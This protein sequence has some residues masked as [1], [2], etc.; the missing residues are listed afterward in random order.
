MEARHD[1]RVSALVRSPIPRPVRISAHTHARPAG[2]KMFGP[3]NRTGMSRV[4]RGRAADVFS[5]AD[6]VERHGT[7]HPRHSV[8]IDSLAR[9]SQPRGAPMNRRAA[10]TVLLLEGCDDS[11]AG[12]GAALRAVGLQVVDLQDCQRALEAITTATPNVIVASLDSQT[13]DDRLSW[14]R[15]IRTDARTRGIPIILTTPDVTP[16]DVALATDPVVLLL[17]LKPSDGAR[18]VAAI[19]RTLAARR[20][21]PSRASPHRRRNATHLA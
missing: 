18:L 8:T 4:R 14:C 21:E 3:L 10:P 11:R 9:R 16:E 13:R 20:A 6:G 2:P 19:N 15:A 17:T 5:A 1:P 7:S 12:Y